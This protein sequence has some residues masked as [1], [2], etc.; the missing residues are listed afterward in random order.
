MNVED[1]RTIPRMDM[2]FLVVRCIR[3]LSLG[4]PQA[5]GVSQGFSSW[6]FLAKRSSEEKEAGPCRATGRRRLTGRRLT[7]VYARKLSCQRRHA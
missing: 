2:G 3:W 6:K 5:Q 4:P 7:R 1:S